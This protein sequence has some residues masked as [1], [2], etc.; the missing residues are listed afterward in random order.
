MI[1]RLIQLYKQRKN[2]DFHPKHGFKIVFAFEIDGKKYYQLDQLL[3]M[4]I[5]RFNFL[6]TFYHEM[7]LRLTTETLNEFLDA[8]R[9]CV[10]EVKLGDALRIIDELKDRSQWFIEEESM[11]RFASV[12]YFTIDE[13]L[14]TYNLAYNKKKI[15]GWRK[16]KALPIILKMWD[17]Q[18]D[19]PLN[20]SIQD[21]EGYLEKQKELAN[22][23]NLYL[24]RL[25]GK[26]ALTT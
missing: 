14:T 16:K 22:Q 20:T 17:S 3:E 18:A 15:D 5:E 23:Q 19:K 21:L 12:Q 2:P 8:A 6:Q 11:L 9:K 1:K 13:D 25:M 4:P 26:S 7:E 10:N 24:E